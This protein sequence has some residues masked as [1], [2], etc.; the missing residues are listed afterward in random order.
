[1]AQTEED[2]P[3]AVVTVIG[4]MEVAAVEDRAVGVIE[5]N[6]IGI[7]SET[8]TALFCPKKSSRV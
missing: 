1:M 4:A 7:R 5:V 8:S 2:L 6:E 3:L